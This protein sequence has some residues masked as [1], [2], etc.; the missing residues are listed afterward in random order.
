MYG[1]HGVIDSH[2]F[3]AKIRS[4]K[5]FQEKITGYKSAISECV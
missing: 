3:E 2:W 5:Y 4:N 1:Q